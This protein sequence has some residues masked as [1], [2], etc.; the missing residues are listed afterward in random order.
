MVTYSKRLELTGSD[1]VEGEAETAR[2]QQSFDDD[3]VIDKHEQKQIDKA[4]RR[5]L[6][7]RGRGR[8][9]VSN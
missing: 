5:Q 4:H 8:A 9:Q 2:K 3:G 7:N 6:E 1:H